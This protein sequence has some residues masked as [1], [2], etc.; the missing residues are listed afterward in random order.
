MSEVEWTWIFLIG[1]SHLQSKLNLA[2]ADSVTGMK[3]S[4]HVSLWTFNGFTSCT[5]TY[6]RKACGIK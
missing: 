4:K 3:P 6:G 2:E 5:E 1:Y